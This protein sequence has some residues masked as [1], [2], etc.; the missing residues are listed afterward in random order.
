MT[1]A[2]DPGTAGQVTGE[3][4]LTPGEVGTLYRVDPRTAARWAAQGW[5]PAVK[6]PGGRWRFRESAVRQALGAPAPGD[7]RT[8]L[9][10]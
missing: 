10:S 6:T 7:V 5:P 9:P 1:I 3:R 2:S 8:E 4:L